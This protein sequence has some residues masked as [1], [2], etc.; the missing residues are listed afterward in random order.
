MCKAEFETNEKCKNMLGKSQKY[1]KGK[2]VHISIFCRK[3]CSNNKMNVKSHKKQCENGKEDK[4]VDP[5]LNVNLV[6][7]CSLTSSICI[8]ILH[9]LLSVKRK[10]MN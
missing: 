6:D 1:S 7:I 2:G 9:H 10:L 8:N 5:M 4:S 3:D